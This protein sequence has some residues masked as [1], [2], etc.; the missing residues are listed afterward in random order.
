M[1]DI[2]E[3][4][5]MV[6]TSWSG[7][8][9]NMFA[10]LTYL[11]RNYPNTCFS[12]DVYIPGTITSNNSSSRSS[13]SG[14]AESSENSKDPSV[15][16]SLPRYRQTPYYLSWICLSPDGDS[17]L[18]PTIYPDPNPDSVMKKCLRKLIYPED[19]VQKFNACK[20]NP[21]VRFIIGFIDI[22]HYYPR[23]GHVNAFLYDKMD[24]SVEV[25]E[26]H[27]SRKASKFDSDEYA[28]AL[29]SFFNSI[30]IKDGDIYMDFCPAISFQSLQFDEPE[31]VIHESD[32]YGFCQSWVLWWIDY[33]LANH[34]SQKSRKELVDHAIATL[35]R[36]PDYLTAFIRNYS[37]FVIRYRDKLLTNVFERLG[38]VEEGQKFIKDLINF[39][40]SDNKLRYRLRKAKAKLAKEVTIKNQ[41]EISDIEKQLKELY[42]RR[43][44]DRILLL[45]LIEEL[46]EAIKLRT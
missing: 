36:K 29:R 30:G 25:F 42:T 27:G 23:S 18:D 40:K 16:H 33:R 1:E 34:K 10:G 8:R 13:N 37:E 39:D 9:I 31:S 15:P 20:N 26:P 21:A 45:Y 11:L 44:N 4:E 24:N 22:R 43:P 17:E 12:M 19:F 38:N 28:E 41:E 3:H 7:D 32:P 5:T 35:K 6:D 2:L 14:S 46:Q